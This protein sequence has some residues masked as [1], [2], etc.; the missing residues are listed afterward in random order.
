M[1]AITFGPG[2]LGMG[3]GQR[4]D[5]VKVTSVDDCSQASAK[6]VVVGSVILQV[7]GESVKGLG[8]HEVLK[9]VKDATRPVNLLLQVEANESPDSN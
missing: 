2:P 8:M 3:I 5:V 4:G 1:V 7:A 9:R 6:G